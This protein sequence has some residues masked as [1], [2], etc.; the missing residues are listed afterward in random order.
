MQRILRQLHVKVNEKVYLKDPESSELGRKIVKESIG[1]IHK[2]GFEAF[3]FKKLAT[4]IHTTESTIYR[5]FEN[6]HKLLLYLTSW[7]WGW[8]EYQM[9]FLTMNVANPVEKLAKTIETICDPLKNNLEHEYV[10]LVLLYEIVVAESPKAYLTKEVDDENKNGFFANY[11]HICERLSGIIEEINPEFKFA[12][13]LASSI[14]ES[15]NQQ[16]FFALH[17][18]KLTN[19]DHNAR[20]LGTFFTEMTLK[21][22]ETA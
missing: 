21:T 20:N 8:M 11:K 19:I 4:E 16:R 6:K 13:T 9:V 2:I 17:L 1:I 15:A 10:D 18:P 12:Q 22:I 3:T 5:Y 14:M 7:Y